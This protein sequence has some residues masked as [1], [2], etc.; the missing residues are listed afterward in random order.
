MR[1]VLYLAGTYKQAAYWAAQHGLVRSAW[2]YVTGPEVL[3]GRRNVVVL[4]VG[5]PWERGDYSA[6]C[7]E[8]RRNGG[9]FH[10]AESLGAEQVA[11]LHGLVASAGAGGRLVV[12]RRSRG[13]AVAPGAVVR[14]R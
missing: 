5:T 10:R 2:R 12:P 14:K 4:E 6:C 11:E 9:V 13:R 1:K 7:N 8:V 3:M